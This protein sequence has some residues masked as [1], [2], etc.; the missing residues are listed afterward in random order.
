MSMMA[1]SYSAEWFD[2]FLRP[3]DPA[4]T[5]REIAFVA[6]QR[7]RPGAGRVLVFEAA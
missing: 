5:A 1:N 4:Q 3:I 2:L 7:P 6:R